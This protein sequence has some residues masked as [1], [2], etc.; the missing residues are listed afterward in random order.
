MALADACH[1]RLMIKWSHVRFA[2]DQERHFRN[3]L[4]NPRTRAAAAR[5]LNRESER[6]K[7]IAEDLAYSELYVRP[8]DRRTSSTPGYHKSFKIVPARE[9]GNRMRAGLRNDHESA[10]WVENGT[11][12]HDIF[13]RNARVLKFPWIGKP[14]GRGSA[15]KLGQFAA[16]F[17]QGNPAYAYHVSHPG[18]G[19]H[20]IMRRTQQR[21]RRET[22][23]ILN[24]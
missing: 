18:A 19:A 4:A 8:P 9:T 3:L 20:H 23:R 12:A 21:Y 1:N 10:P 24:R 5:L 15:G 6:L 22:S 17:G 14:S 16:T 2:P 7:F 13:P 11:Q